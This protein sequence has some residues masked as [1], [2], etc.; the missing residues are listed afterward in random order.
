VLSKMARPYSHV[1]TCLE[2]LSKMASAR[3]RSV[4]LQSQSVSPKNKTK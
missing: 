2:V 4:L 1:T 3:F